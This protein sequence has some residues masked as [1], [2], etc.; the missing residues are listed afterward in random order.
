[1]GGQSRQSAISGD[2][3][4]VALG[5]EHTGGGPAQDHGSALPAFDPPRDPAHP[6]EQV[7]VVPIPGPMLGDT[8]SVTRAREPASDALDNRRDSHPTADAHR[9]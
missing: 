4:E 5:F 3:A 6:A 1:M 2:F 7:T 8:K 9:D